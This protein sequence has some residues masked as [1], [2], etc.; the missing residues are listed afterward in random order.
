MKRDDTLWKA[1]LEDVFDDFLRFFFPNADE[2]FYLDRGFEYLDKELE[3]LFPPEQDTYQLRYVDKLVK[4]FTRQASKPVEQWILIHIEVQG[5]RDPHFAERMFQYYYRIFDKYRQ[6]ITAIALFTD[7]HKG[8]HP[9]RYEQSYLGTQLSYRYNTYKIRDQNEANLLANPNPFALVILT[10][11][12]AL[13]AGTLSEDELLNLKLSIAKSLLNSQISKNKVRS[14]LNFL[15]YYV[16]LE[17]PVVNSKF[18]KEIES[19][20]QS[21][22]PMGIE[23]FLLDRA[24]KEGLKEGLEKGL[25]QGVEQEKRL[26]VASLLT[27]T[28]FSSE[29]IADIVNVPVAFVNQIRKSLPPSSI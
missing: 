4:V 26:V 5:Y 27:K 19:I 11:K 28:G 7:S 21:S 3:Q 14:I 20:T 12:T 8:Y 1:I 13:K 10:A 2:L 29:Q 18:E 17:N 22:K 24:K 25:E 15:R 23:E 6:P 16:R 9:S